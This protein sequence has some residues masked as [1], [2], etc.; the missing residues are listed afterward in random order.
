MPANGARSPSAP[1]VE[2]CRRAAVSALFV[3]RLRRGRAAGGFSPRARARCQRKLGAHAASPRT[4]GPPANG[5]C[6]S[7]RHL[8]SLSFRLG[9]FFFSAGGGSEGRGSRRLL[10]ERGWPAPGRH[11]RTDEPARPAVP[12]S[13]S[14]NTEHHAAAS[15]CVGLRCAHSLPTRP[16]GG[17]R[18]AARAALLLILVSVVVWFSSRP[19]SPASSRPVRVY[20]VEGKLASKTQS[21][22]D[23]RLPSSP[24]R[25]AR[26][27]ALSK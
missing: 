8:T 12:G 3:I 13:F 26:G 9:E 16:R 19:R 15:R 20:G 2:G 1:L 22:W 7:F 6:G 24:H 17:G 4:G 23:I 25:A 27:P 10:L 5:S 18:S 21:K 14:A 11:P